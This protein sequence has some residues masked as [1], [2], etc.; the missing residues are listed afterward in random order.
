MQ[1]KAGRATLI[2]D[3]IVFRAKHRSSRGNESSY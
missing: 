1:N 2:T 3:N